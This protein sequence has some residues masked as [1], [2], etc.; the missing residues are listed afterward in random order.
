M[1][2]LDWPYE[3]ARPERSGRARFAQA[4]S[5]ICLDFHGD[6]RSAQLV[7]F[8]DGNHHMALEGALRAFLGAHPQAGDVFYAT[9]PPRVI[10]DALKVG[11]TRVGNLTLAVRPHVFISP[12]PVLERLLAEGYVRSHRP[13]ARSLGA[14]LLVR[15]GNPK[16][17]LEIADLARAEVRVF[18]S[19]PVTE[20]VSHRAYVETLKKVAARE[21]VALDMLDADTKPARLVYGEAIHHREAPQC[22]ADG[23][24]DVAVVF[25]HLALRYV[26][27]FPDDF[28]MVRLGRGAG[29]DPDHVVSD[30][31]AGLVGDGGEWGARL[32]EFMTS[33]TVARIYQSHGLATVA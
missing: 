24:A 25:H 16:R 19:N 3:G 27:I 7:V 15:N 23:R 32:V 9:T 4:G 17:I 26:R 10:V 1:P 29:D 28:E 22:I 2:D 20:E 13:F 21:R 12:A 33:E 31:H 5:N 14:A 30:I 6:P 18:L 8:S 11:G